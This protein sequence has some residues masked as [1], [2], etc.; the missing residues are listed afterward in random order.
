MSTNVRAE[1][2]TEMTRRF[3]PIHSG[4][5]DV[6][7]VLRVPWAM[8]AEH[9]AQAKR[10]HSQTLERLAERGG[11]CGKEILAILSGENWNHFE[12]MKGEVVASHLA[13]MIADWYD[14]QISVSETV[15]VGK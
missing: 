7:K 14:A 1:G 5:T 15:E 4:S 3:F 10:N 12:G 11:C 8:I 2:E 6:E 9:G 13:L